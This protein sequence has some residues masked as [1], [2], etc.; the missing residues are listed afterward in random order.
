MRGS[1]SDGRATS[2]PRLGQESAQSQAYA[3]DTFI[4]IGPN[5]DDEDI[6]LSR[7]LKFQ[8]VIQCP[9]L[10]D[11]SDPIPIPSM[12]HG[13]AAGRNKSVKLLPDKLPIQVRMEAALFLII[14]LGPAPMLRCYGSY[15]QDKGVL[16][17]LL[18]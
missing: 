14:E 7:V 9:G 12:P 11:T 2:S 17:R 18:K 15:R 13:F 10:S 6:V 4:S 1:H 5:N 3:I 8:A 16:P